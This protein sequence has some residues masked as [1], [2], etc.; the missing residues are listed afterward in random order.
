VTAIP[1]EAIVVTGASTGIGAAAAAGLA[2]LG[3]VVFAG[4][5]SDADASVVRALHENVCALLLDVTDA[6]EVAAA[7][8]A[9]AASGLPVRGVVNN[10]GIAVGGPLEFLPVDELRR[11]F[12]VNLFGA[13]AVTQA[14][15]PLLRPARG[16]L[17]FLGSSSGRLA[18]PFVAPYSASKFA[19]RAVTDALRVELSPF[20]LSVSL[21]E[22]GSVKTPIW[23]KGRDGKERLLGLL[24]P[25]AMT[26]YGPVIDAMFA[27]TE[28]EERT[29]MPVERVTAAIV[30]ALTARK[31][32]PNYLLGGPARAG[33]ILALFPAGLR[34][35][36]IK[37]SMRLP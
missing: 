25:T 36:A 1:S 35:R 18:T 34:D 27:A 20:G 16:R 28:N 13:V 9:V 14:F 5:R 22:P 31:P 19:L 32:K 37:K 12:E 10:A 15:L 17:V 33:S 2:R 11:Q 4:V 6:E 30:H 21:I 23:Q 8:D 7:A 24:G 29:G 26:V 3:Y